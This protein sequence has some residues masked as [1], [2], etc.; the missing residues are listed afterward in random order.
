VVVGTMSQDWIDSEATT[1]YRQAVDAVH[2]DIGNLVPNAALA[3]LS[4]ISAG[5]HFS[6]DQY[7]LMGEIY[8]DAYRNLLNITHKGTSKTWLDSNGLVTGGDYAA[9]ELLDSDFDG[10]AN[11][12]EFRDGTNPTNAASLLE[13]TDLSRSGNQLALTWQA[14]SSK[15]YTMWYTPDLV[16]KAWIRKS[17]GLVG[18]EPTSTENVQLDGGTGFY[19]FQVEH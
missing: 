2:R 8:Y 6:A 11:W 10:R 12:I 5:I 3:D 14:V 9:A 19:T 15:T 4:A 18:S 1:S 17:A 16:N 7:Q 13:I